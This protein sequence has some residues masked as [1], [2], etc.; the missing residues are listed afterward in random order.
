M[1][2]RASCLATAAPHRLLPGWDRIRLQFCEKPGVTGVPKLRPTVWVLAVGHRPLRTHGTGGHSSG[3]AQS[4]HRLYVQSSVLVWQGSRW[5]SLGKYPLPGFFILQT[6]P[7][8]PL[9]SMCVCMYICVYIYIP[10]YI[11]TPCLV[12]G[13]GQS[14]ESAPFYLSDLKTQIK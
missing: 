9:H 11:H 3:S 6:V 4:R 1:T 7:L 5:S 12:L 14:G 13:Q 8:P 10:T 2:H